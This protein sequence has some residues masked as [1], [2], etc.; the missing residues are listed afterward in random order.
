MVCV[1]VELNSKNTIFGR[2]SIRVIPLAGVSFDKNAPPCLSY[3]EIFCDTVPQVHSLKVG[4]I[5]FVEGSS[6][7]FE[8]I[9]E[10]SEGISV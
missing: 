1:S 10:L 9:R 4:I 3:L 6:I 8:L 2:D 5:A 7:I